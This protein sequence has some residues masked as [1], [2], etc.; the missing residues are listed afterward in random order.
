MRS[1]ILIFVI[2]FLQLSCYSQKAIIETKN[3]NEIITQG[4]FMQQDTGLKLQLTN[5]GYYILFNPENSGHFVMEQCEFAS[6]GKWNQLSSDVMEIISENYYVQQDGFKYDLKKENKYSKDSIYIE[7]KLPNEFLNSR[8]EVIK[9]TFYFN[10]NTNKTITTKKN[11]IVIAKEKY[12]FAKPNEVNHIGFSLNADI[13]G[14]SI[15]ESRIMFKIFEEDINTEKFNNITINLPNFNLCFYEF[16]TYNH[17]LIYIKNQK[18]LIWQ[19]KIWKK[20]N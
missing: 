20:I 15:Y 8:K 3:D 19:G 5:E 4:V 9:S 13:L 7:L 16:E 1:K 6:K 11:S 18:E 2:L 17:E 10:H 14:T 12:L